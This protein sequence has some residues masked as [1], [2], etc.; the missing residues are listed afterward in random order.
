MTVFYDYDDEGYVLLSLKHYLDGGHLY[1]D[2]FT[3]YGPF[4]YLVQWLFFRGLHFPIT[5]DGGRLVT[6]IYW[7][8]SALLAG[9]FIQRISKSLVLGGAAALGCVTV[10]AFLANE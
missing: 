9:A 4:Y 1:T 3:N 5:H 2:T 7:L 8:I 6:L 10:G